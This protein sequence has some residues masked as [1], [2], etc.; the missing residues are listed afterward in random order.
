MYKGFRLAS[1]FKLNAQN[2]PSKERQNQVDLQLVKEMIVSGEPIDAQKV[3]DKLFPIGTPDVFLSHSFND[4]GDALQ[5]AA[6]MQDLGLSV[7]IDSEVW[8][9]VYDLLREVDDQYCWQA[10]TNTYYYEKRNQSTAH[11]YMV[12]NTALHNMI[13]RSE[14]FLFIGSENSLVASASEMTELG[15]EQKTFSP[16]IHSELMIS[17]MIRR[18]SPPRYSGRRGAAKS[19]A[20]T[21]VFDEAMNLEV[22]HPAPVKHLKFL[23][24]D[25]LNKWLAVGKPIDKHSLD[26]LYSLIG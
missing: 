11:V 21:E 20:S 9:S 19:E 17:S 5:L 22:H 24:S 26:E 25:I 6:A 8:G 13:D 4:R 15:D 2:R 18:T 7:F 14:A 10:M 23:R 1:G 3:A 16:W 12:L